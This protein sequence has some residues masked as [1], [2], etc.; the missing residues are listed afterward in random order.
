M[1]L[2][3]EAIYLIILKN[4]KVLMMMGTIKN[5]MLTGLQLVNH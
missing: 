5:Y 3:L 1:L 2:T 4:I